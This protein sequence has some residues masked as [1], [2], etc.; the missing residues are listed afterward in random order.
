[1]DSN[2]TYHSKDSNESKEWGIH[3][4]LQKFRVTSSDVLDAIKAVGSSR[5]DIEWYLSRKQKK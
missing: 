5:Q 2:S 4:L 3:Y 1:M